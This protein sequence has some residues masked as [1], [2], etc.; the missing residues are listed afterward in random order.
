MS[1][2]SIVQKAPGSSRVRSSTRIPESGTSTQL[3]ETNKGAG[4]LILHAATGT[5][6][7]SQQSTAE[8]VLDQG[9][10][11]VRRHLRPGLHYPVPP[12]GHE[13]ADALRAAGHRRAPTTD[14]TP[15]GV[16]QGPSLF[17]GP[18]FLA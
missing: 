2:S 8:R 15:A 9:A 12:A 4:A 1:A 3:W 10:R 6:H 16:R 17:S 18:R 7:A 5:H 14:P 11:P 13:P